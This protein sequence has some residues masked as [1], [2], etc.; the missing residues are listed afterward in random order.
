MSA[1]G[2]HGFADGALAASG[3]TDGQ[4]DTAPF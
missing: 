1:T 4:T 2:L 3:Q